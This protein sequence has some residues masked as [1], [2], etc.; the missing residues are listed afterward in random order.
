MGTDKTDHKNIG[1]NK[2]LNRWTI[3]GLVVAPIL[4]YF[5]YTPNETNAASTSDSFD[6]AVFQTAERRNKNASP[7]VVGLIIRLGQCSDR[8][9]SGD[10]SRTGMVKYVN[11]GSN[12]KRP[13]T[14]QSVCNERIERRSNNNN[15]W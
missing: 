14:R 15:N 5:G 9:S 6:T 10:R 1:S 8:R 7:H 12:T 13:I 11:S 4:C 3:N 2:S